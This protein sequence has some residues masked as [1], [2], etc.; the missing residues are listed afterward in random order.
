[1]NRRVIIATIPTI[2]LA[3][4]VGDD[5]EAEPPDDE[6]DEDDEPT[7]PTAS[8]SFAD[9]EEGE[10]HIQILYQSGDT[11]SFDSCSL[12]IG[13]R[14]VEDEMTV[15]LMS[16][17]EVEDWGE[18]SIQAG[19]STTV[20]LAEDGPGE[21]ATVELIFDPSGDALAEGEIYVAESA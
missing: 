15:P 6:A 5:E 2:V 9:G 12:A 1:M 17:V 19:Q 11:A 10:Y 18:D 3:G 4:C 8:I 14:E 21:Q 7:A 16:E 13:G 20:I